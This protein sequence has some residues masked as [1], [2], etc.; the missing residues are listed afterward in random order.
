MLILPWIGSYMELKKIL[1]IFKKN[2]V[3][4]LV[5]V[6]IGAVVGAYLGK[7]YKDVPHAQLDVFLTPKNVPKVQANDNYY[8]QEEARNFTDS[9]VV[10]LE[11]PD[12]AKG[13]TQSGETISASKLSAQLI[14]LTASALSDERASALLNDTINKFNTK[15]P[16]LTAEDRTVLLKPIATEPRNFTPAVNT[17]VLILTGALFGFLFAAFVISLREYLDR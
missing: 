11:S 9:A 16:E 5:F 17:K 4:L 10:I 2:V 12:F 14:R 13:L 6:V 3:Y 7:N 15:I 8:L 1:T